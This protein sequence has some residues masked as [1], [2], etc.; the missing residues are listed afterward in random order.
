VTALGARREKAAR[1]QWVQILRNRLRDQRRQ[2]PTSVQ[3][4]HNGLTYRAS[5]LDADPSA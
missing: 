1:F 4:Q 3:S 5:I 2:P